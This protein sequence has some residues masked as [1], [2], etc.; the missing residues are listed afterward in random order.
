MSPPK[1]WALP[2]RVTRARRLIL[3]A[4]YNTNDDERN[5]LLEAARCMLDQRS[6]ALFTERWCMDRLRELRGSR[7]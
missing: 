4:R 2:K 7:Q 3:S 6:D 1:S 5:V